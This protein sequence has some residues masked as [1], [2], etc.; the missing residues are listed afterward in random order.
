MV[1]TACDVGDPHV[2]VLQDIPYPID[3]LE[4]G[5]GVPV[6]VFVPALRCILIPFFV[7]AL[8][9]ALVPGAAPS[10]PAL[11][12]SVCS[13]FPCFFGSAC[14]V[15]TRSAAS[16]SGQGSGQGSKKDDEDRCDHSRFQGDPLHLLP[17]FRTYFCIARDLCSAAA[18]D[19]CDR[20][21]FIH[22]I[23]QIYRSSDAPCRL[24]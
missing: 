4:G 14:T 12:F 19:F 20:F 18:A 1:V 23:L 15:C 13:G 8:R 22:G 5:C 9:G 3:F 10:L 2:P 24:F 17:A 16:A 11:C 21:S 7:S 6:S